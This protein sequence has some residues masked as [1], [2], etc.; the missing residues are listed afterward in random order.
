M[1]L[2]ICY[3][4]FIILLIILILNC[5]EYFYNIDSQEVLNNYLGEKKNHNLS[6]FGYSKVDDMNNRSYGS[7]ELGYYYDGIY[8]ENGKNKCKECKKCNIEGKKTIGGCMGNKN[9]ICDEINHNYKEF[10]LGHKSP[11]NFH[12]SLKP[13]IHTAIKPNFFPSHFDNTPTPSPSPSLSEI[14]L[15]SNELHTHVL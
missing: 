6:E 5:K 15:Q 7:C 14:Y 12:S 1:K 4:I 9:S 10:H 13:H 8:K 11:K 3:F 2:N